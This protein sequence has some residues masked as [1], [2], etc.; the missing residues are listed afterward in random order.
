VVV[1][2]GEGPTLKEG[3]VVAV[4]EESSQEEKQSH[5]KTR[6]LAE[7]SERRKG[8]TPMGYLGR[9]ALRRAQCDA[10]D[11]LLCNG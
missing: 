2:V 1:A 4:G 10:L 3:V 11:H 7:T 6:L 8:D 5:K 9:R